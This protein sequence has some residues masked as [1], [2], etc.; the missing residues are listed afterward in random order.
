M[1]STISPS[2]AL[3]RLYALDPEIWESLSCYLRSLHARI[4]QQ[5]MRPLGLDDDKG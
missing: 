5:T 1:P 3:E 2:E 4:D